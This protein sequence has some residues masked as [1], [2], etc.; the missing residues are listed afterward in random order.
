MPT[1]KK[2]S[3]SLRSKAARPAPPEYPHVA[4]ALQYCADVIEGVEPTSKWTILACKRHLSDLER[5]DAAGHDFPYYFDPVQA[6]RVCN[7]IEKLPHVKGKWARKDP[8]NPN[9]HRLK[10][11]PWQCFFVCSIFGWLM[12]GTERKLPS[13]RVIGLRRFKEADLW[14]ARKNAKST[15]AAGI[16]HWMFGKD[17][18]P[19]AEVYCGAGT[20]K[21]AWEVFGPVRQMC[22]AEPRLVTDLGITLN[23]KSLIR[24]HAG[25]LSK[26]EPVIGKPGDGASPHCAIIDEY[27][28]HA[29][30]EQ[31]DTFKT[32]MGAREQPLLLIISTAGFNSKGP[33]RDH[34]RDGEKILEGTIEN[35]RRFVLIFTVNDPEEDWKTEHGLRM[36]N[37]NWGVS[38]NKANILADLAEALRDAKKQ[39]AFKT[40]HANVWVT[41]SQAYFNLENWNRCKSPVALLVTSFKQ[42]ICY[43]GGDFASKV[44]LAAVAKCFPMEGGRYALFCRYYSPL[45]T[46]QLTQNQHLWKWAQEKWLT[47][48]PGNIID[49]D[50]I[51][52]DI[53]EDCGQYSLKEI[54]IDPWQATWM[55]TQLRAKKVNAFEFRQIVSM[56]SEPMK[57]L[58]ALMRDGKLL[59]D[60]NP[61]TSWCLSNVKGQEDKKENVYPYKER[62]VEFIDGAIAILMAFARAHVNSVQA[63]SVYEGRGL[64]TL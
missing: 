52:D 35:E 13:G 43:A 23:A 55:I 32:G 42:K 2:T 20:E 47:A 33:A 54:A 46:V 17:E 3:R 10:L 56:M 58:D 49:F 60:G 30:S 31:Y 11:M 36:A 57:Q 34:W 22:V 28:E 51:R 19:G 7:Y 5:A 12:V 38:V 40:K 61:I 50:T 6:E 64:R 18:E 26:F 37:P 21:Q 15:I 41:V 48:T 1:K 14:V 44:N 9:A 29:S 45:A 63:K 53:I 62:D 8:I 24:Q 39:S 27:H 16:G 25:A 4:L 59:H